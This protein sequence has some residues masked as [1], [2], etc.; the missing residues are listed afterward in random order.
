M[1]KNLNKI[2]FLD[3]DGVINRK[4]D[5]D[6]VKFWNE[7]EFLPGVL[8]SLALLNQKGYALIV[9]SNQAGV[10]K[11]LMSLCDLKDI[12]L[13]M[14]QE[15][16]EHDGHI[17]EAYYCRHRDEDECMCRKPNPGLFQQ[18]FDDL[19]L[20]S[21]TLDELWIIGD[22]ERDIVAGHQVGCQGIL[23]GPA[24]ARPSAAEFTATDL[25]A[26]VEMIICDS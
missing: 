17:L 1:R 2:I 14:K 12:D 23:V 4:L 3:R 26:A 13:C 5:N 22:S 8:D 24:T 20:N 18:A 7:F 25:P 6:Y 9:A 11:N 10:N 19:E 15:V 21:Q 16:L